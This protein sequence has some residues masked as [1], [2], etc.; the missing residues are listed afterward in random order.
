M[1]AGARCC[2]FAFRKKRPGPFFFLLEWV[3]S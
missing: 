2:S 3:F 1:F